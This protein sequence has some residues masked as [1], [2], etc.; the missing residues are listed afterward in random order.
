M[1]ADAVEVTDSRAYPLTREDFQTDQIVRWC[2]GCGDYAILAQVQ[3]TLPDFDVP[4]ENTVFI[5]GIGC[6]SR[7]PYYMNTYGFHS[8]HGR[9][10]VIAT[11]LKASRPELDVWIVTGDGDS[12][13]IGANHF[14]HMC[15][16]NLNVVVL[17]FNN[18][19]Y[20]L[21]KG[22]Y[23]P[24]SPQGQRSYSSPGGS[25]DAPFNPMR[26]A[27]GANASFVARAVDRDTKHLSEMIRR[28]HAHQGTSILEIYQDCIVYNKGAF[29]ELTD[30]SSKADEVLYLEHGAPMVFGRAKDKGIRL[31]GLEPR[32]VSLSDG[33]YS[34]AD[35]LVHDEYD[36][37]GTLCDI[38]ASFQERKDFPRP[39]GVIRNIERACYEDMLTH[40]L[41]AASDRLGTPSLQALFEEGD[42]WVAPDM[43]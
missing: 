18:Q 42:T 13:S 9:A 2:P 7:F 31:V 27:L 10:A 43:E 11:G 26:V 23:S 32:V 38:L 3:R 16:R 20:G 15:R 12:L 28:S 19:I 14:L 36:T 4:R 25:I 40:Q 17:L 22:Q 30:K 5:S 29:H 39:L 8:I 37:H 34:V 41:A 1:S 21:T 35:V 33:K 24:T 6:S